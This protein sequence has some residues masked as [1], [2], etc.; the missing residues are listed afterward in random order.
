[1]AIPVFDDGALVHKPQMMGAFLRPHHR[2]LPTSNTVHQSVSRVFRPPIVPYRMA[3]SH[4]SPRPGELIPNAVHLRRSALRG[5]ALCVARLSAWRYLLRWRFS[6]G[7]VSPRVGFLPAWPFSGKVAVSGVD[8]LAPLT[9][10]D[11]AC[12]GFGAGRS[13]RACSWVCCE[14]YRVAGS[15]GLSA[16]LVVDGS[17]CVWFW[18]IEFGLFGPLPP[19]DPDR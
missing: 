19:D 14:S 10:L 13:R 7:G 6:W 5:S 11:V 9:R 2:H 3:G 8:C 4:R 18:Q 17:G 12:V 16:V 15:F 1:M